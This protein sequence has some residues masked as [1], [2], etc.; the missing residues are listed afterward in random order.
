MFGQEEIQQ[1]VEEGKKLAE[2]LWETFT[3]ATELPN[4]PEAIVLSPG[5]ISVIVILLLGYLYFRVGR[6]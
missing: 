6:S 4:L 5:L 2:L 3:Y 1:L